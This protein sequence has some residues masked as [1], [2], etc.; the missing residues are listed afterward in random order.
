MADVPPAGPAERTPESYTWPLVAILI[1]ILPQVLVPARDRIGPLGLVPTAEATAFLIMLVI[2]AKPG[3]VPRRARPAIL[4]LFGVLIAAN[5]VAA[6]RL[7]VLVLQGGKL[8][9]VPLSAQRLLVAGSLVLLANVITFGLVYWQ[10][11]SGGPAGRAV[12]PVPYPDFQF[13]QTGTQGLA[14]SG[15]QPRFPD[16]LYVS[17]TSVVAFS[18]TDTLPLTV[19]AK[20][21]MALQAMISLAVLVVVL[22]RVIN[23]L[24]S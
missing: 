20:A 16:H 3:P 19:R 6:G 9:G 5:A 2:A 12:D 1:A 11:D 23:I 14:P 10:I 15:W 22:A 8:D 18:P 7:V 21:L 13:P 4:T 24:P 17:F